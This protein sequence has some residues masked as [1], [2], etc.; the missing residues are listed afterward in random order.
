MRIPKILLMIGVA[1]EYERGLITG[2]AKYSEI[3]GPWT[4]YRMAPFYYDDYP[5]SRKFAEKKV[6]DHLAEWSPDGV[7]AM[8][9]EKLL[10]RILDFNVPLIAAT[11]VSSDRLENV[12]IISADYEQMGKVAAEHL[13]NKGFKSFAF[14]GIGET[15]WA[16]QREVGFAR[17]LGEFGFEANVYSPPSKIKDRHWAFEQRFLADWIDSL[18]KPLGVMACNDNRSQQV[19]EACKIRD[20]KVPEQVAIL[21]VDND[22]FVCD[23]SRPTLSSIILDTEGAGFKAAQI[24]HDMIDGR[25]PDSYD[26]KIHPIGIEPRRSTDILAIE[27]DEVARA[28]NFIN[29]NF[30]R[31][32]QVDDVVT[33]SYTSRRTLERRFKENLGTSVNSEIK[34]LRIEHIS[35]LLLNTNMS[36]T[37]I[38]KT[39]GFVETDHFSRYFG[40]IMGLTPVAFRKKHGKY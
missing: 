30:K 2:I 22:K 11:S 14:C 9:P 16:K 15:V 12:P 25:A 39:M 26:I 28:V 17:T 4:F 1:T 7:I 40:S 20:I 8:A 5:Y 34:R 37:E 19:M 23:L 33:A 18:P 6:M 38:A 29:E 21:G 36:V 31:N 10:G 35:R 24:L 13:I 3:H 27:D 32:I